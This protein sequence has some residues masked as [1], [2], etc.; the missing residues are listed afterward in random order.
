MLGVVVVAVYSLTDTNLRYTAE[1]PKNLILIIGDGMGPQQ[2]SLLLLYSDYLKKKSG[3]PLAIERF[4]SK[5][6]TGLVNPKPEAA[7]ITESAC[8]ATE[9]ATGQ[10]GTLEGLGIDGSGRRLETIL[11]KSKR[12][13]KSTGLITDTRITHATPAAFAVHTEHRDNES[14]I[15]YDMINSGADLM[16]GGGADFFK[17]SSLSRTDNIMYAKEKGYKIVQD[18]AELD[19]LDTLPVIGAFSPNIMPD[20]ITEN[21]NQSAAGWTIPTLKELTEKSLK[22]LSSNPKGFFLMVEAGQ[23]DWAGH[24]NDAGQ[25]LYEMKK[26]NSVIE[27]VLNWTE[28]REDTLVVLTADHETGSFGFAYKASKEGTPLYIADPISARNKWKPP[29]SYIDNNIFEVMLSQKKPLIDIMSEIEMVPENKGKLESVLRILHENLPY[30]FN[31]EMALRLLMTENIP[32]DWQPQKIRKWAAIDDFDSF[33]PD[34]I[35]RRPA[36]LARLIADQQG[37]V[38][39][40]GTHT[41]TLVPVLTIGR[42]SWKKEFIGVFTSRELGSR[43]QKVFLS[44]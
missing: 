40:S 27:S 35:D 16:F 18:R 4:I 20:G 2:L 25:L 37:V 6:G 28:R 21:N 29:I 12:A 39:G 30:E 9:L 14:K 15:A 19:S 1:N 3:E 17:P 11:E 42:E 32:K 44:K 7:I 5:C 10:A 33:Y 22:L 23:I 34:Y 31:E 13:G 43:M 24:R 41:S 8:S 38:W 36:M 26:L